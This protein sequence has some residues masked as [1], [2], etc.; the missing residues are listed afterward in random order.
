[1]PWKLINRD[2]DHNFF[3]IS[4]SVARNAIVWEVKLQYLMVSDVL[5]VFS[6]AKTQIK[7]TRSRDSLLVRAPDSWSKGCE[8]ES[9]QER[10]IIFFS[11]VYFVCWLLFGVHFTPVL[12]QWHIKDPS[13]SAKSAGARLHLNTHTPLTHRSRIGL[14]MPLFRQSVRIYQDTSSHTT[15]QGTLGHSCLSWLGHCGLILA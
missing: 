15:R 8:F 14:T 5:F 11:R 4:L 1:M 7:H 2:S 3:F 9:R 10:R 13:H 6:S 12:P